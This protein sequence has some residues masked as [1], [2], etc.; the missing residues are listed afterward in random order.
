MRVG[1]GRFTFDSGMRTLLAD[2]Q[3]VHLSPKAFDVLK[4]LLERR[5]NVVDKQE[6]Y[7]AIWPGTF[8]GDATLNVVV[9]EIRRVLGDDPRTPTYIRTVHRIGYAFS[10]DPVADCRGPAPSEQPSASHRS[11][12]AVDDRTF[13]LTAGENVVGRDPQCTI[14]LDES[15]ISRRHAR[16]VVT[17][18]SATIEDLSSKNGTFVGR[19]RIKEPRELVDGDQIRFGSTTARFR[20]WAEGQPPETVRLDRKR[21]RP[22]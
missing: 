19:R 3:P 6:L 12:L 15:G 2:G 8:V 9:A 5:P 11:W 18:A 1:F 14:W 22:A 17:G 21:G 4:L 10:F 16:I 20:M 13:R 7:A